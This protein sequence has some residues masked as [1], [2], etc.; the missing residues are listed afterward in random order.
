[1]GGSYE[2]AHL[3]A[4]G[5]DQY[6]IYP[7][8][9]PEPLRH[10]SAL[11][12]WWRWCWMESRVLQSSQVRWISGFVIFSPILVAILCHNALVWC[13]LLKCLCSYL[14]YQQVVLMLYQNKNGCQILGVKCNVAL[15]KIPIHYW[16]Y[17]NT[18]IHKTVSYGGNSRI[19]I[20]TMSPPKR[21]LPQDF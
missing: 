11:P 19:R 3:L 18:Y 21:R 17:S 4:P 12:P 16:R 9:K 14:V 8:D 15:S 20:H 1:M 10:G 6:N 5:Y 2:R 7:R 13:F